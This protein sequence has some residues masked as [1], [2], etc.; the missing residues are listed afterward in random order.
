MARK[1]NIQNLS[2]ILNIKYSRCFASLNFAKFYST[3]RLRIVALIEGRLGSVEERE[4]EE[5][6]ACRNTR[7]AAYPPKP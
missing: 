5:A 7:A 1:L 2:L 3:A 6:N 4:D